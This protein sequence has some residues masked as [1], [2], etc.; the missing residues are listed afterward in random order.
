[1]DGNPDAVSAGRLTSQDADSL[2]LGRRLPDVR[3][4]LAREAFVILAVVGVVAVL[5]AALPRMVVPDTW[6]AL[7]DGRWISAHG[8]P[9]HDAIAAWT[10]GETW[11]D[12]QWLA[13]LSLYALASLGGVK[14][15]LAV[16]MLIDLAAIAVAAFAARKSGAS[17]RSTALC[18]L[19]AFLVAPW[20]LQ[21]RTQTLALPLFVAVYALLAADARRPSNRVLLA[22]PL[23]VVWANVHG[24]AALGVALTFLAGLI[25]LGKR[26]LQGLVLAVGG[27]LCLLASPYGF[28]LVGY[29]R[30][31]LIGSPLPHYVDEW[32]PTKL[33]LD[34][35]AFFVLAFTTV[36]LLAR[37]ARA[38]TLFERLALVALLLVG[39]LAGR[40]TGWLGLGFAV[41]GPLLL[42]ALWPPAKT[43]DPALRRANVVLASVAIAIAA[44]AVAVRLAQP[45]TTLLAAWRTDGSAAAATAAGP[46]GLVLADDLHSDWLLWQRPELTGRVAYD[47]RFELLRESQLAALQ[48]FRDGGGPKSFVAPYRVLTFGSRGDASSLAPGAR[49][50]YVSPSFVVVER[51]N[52][53]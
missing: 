45:E 38:V 39:L 47:V 52:N 21:A 43:V 16:A 50:V 37:Y 11:I 10:R 41:S 8:L 25:A 34:T 4:V 18:L 14:L 17:P 1:M 35:L 27:P 42:D 30:R 5:A 48:R 53:S 9:H 46:R 28:G 49:T 40:N 13:H 36:F 32:A 12:Q 3:E 6:L 15:V 20:L 2:P 26:R 22:L 29:Y 33:E 44:L 19:A 24:S 51:R 7:V 31:M 23:L